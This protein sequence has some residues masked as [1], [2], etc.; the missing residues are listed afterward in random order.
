MRVDVRTLE[1]ALDPKKLLDPGD[2]TGLVPIALFNR[3]DLAPEDWSNCGEHRIVYSFKAPIP[4]SSGPP[5][6][7][8]LIFEARVDNAS[9]QKSGFEGCRP[10][11]NFWRDLSDENDVSKRAQRLEDFYYKGISGV[12]G[13]VVQAK[14][15]G[16]PLGQVRGNL[17]VNAPGTQP[18][19]QL[20]EW[21]VI[22]AGQPTP[23]SFISFTS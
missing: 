11:A 17:F 13:P 20:R 7:L 18:L 19:W 16:G 9:P 22:N 14:N 6:R 12:S 2:P 1:A 5:A 21:I 4:Q 8:F 23:A 10:V 15:Y 3:L